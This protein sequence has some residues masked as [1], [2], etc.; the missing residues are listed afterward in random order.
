MSY[1]TRSI[2]DADLKNT[3]YLPAAA[4]TNTSD[5]FDLGGGL[6]PENVEVKIIVP[7]L[8]NHTDSTKIILLDLYDSS[9]DSSF[10]VVAPLIECKVPGVASTGSL[11]TT[12]QFSLPKGVARYVRFLQTVPSGDGDNTGGLVTYSLAF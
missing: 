4:A 3:K 8:A 7:A 2:E 11:E 1:N 9:D 6:R 5:S 10:T 12:F